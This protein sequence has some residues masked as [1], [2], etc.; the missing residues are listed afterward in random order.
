MAVVR[1]YKLA[2]TPGTIG[3]TTDGLKLQCIAIATLLVIYQ[4]VL[5]VVVRS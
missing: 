2:E 1:V 5:V 4:Y 3:A